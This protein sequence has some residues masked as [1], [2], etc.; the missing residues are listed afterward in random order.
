MNCNDA[1]KISVVDFLKKLGIQPVKIV[2]NE[3]WYISPLRKEGEPSF[4]VSGALNLWFDHGLGKGGNIVDLATVLFQCSV[5]EALKRLEN[6]RVLEF[7]HTNQIIKEASTPVIVNESIELNDIV[8]LRYITAR[9][10]D[11]DFVKR[12]SKE[13]HYL[14]NDIQ[15]KA[16]GL[17][18]TA[19]GWELHTPTRLGSFKNST[20]PKSISHFK[21]DKPEVAVFEGQFDFYSIWT[22]NQ[23]LAQSCDFI[24]L[25]SLSLKVKA[26]DLLIQYSKIHLFLDNDTA[27]KSA[28]SFFLN[29]EITQ[30]K[31]INHSQAYGRSKDLNDHLR[32]KFMDRTPEI[33]PKNSPVP[34]TPNRG[35]S[36]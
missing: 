25:N 10:V 31:T 26:I 5:Q 13:I 20:T 6:G 9:K 1:K 8:L 3:Y 30:G 23:A 15:F 16:I 7:E 29:L 4:K 28:S 24:I 34:K 36:L 17:P 32:G 14:V 19:E 21:L 12:F 18:T 2:N 11:L 22:Y 27:G 35:I 33:T